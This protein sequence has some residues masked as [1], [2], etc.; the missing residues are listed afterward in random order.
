MKIL[1][2]IHPLWLREK[3][4]FHVIARNS[5]LKTPGG[6]NLEFAPV[7]MKALLPTDCGH[8]QIAWCGFYELDLSRRISSLAKTGGCLV[9]V[10][11]NAGY[12]SCIW[13][14]ANPLNEVYAFEPSPRNLAMLHRTYRLWIV[15]RG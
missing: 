4:Y 9:D 3:I 14:A 10:G 13:A 6:G 2:T 11:A 1:R 5:S 15:R 7:R 12:F 8:R